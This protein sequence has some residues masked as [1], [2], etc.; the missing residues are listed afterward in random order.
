MAGGLTRMNFTTQETSAKAKLFGFT[1]AQ[2]SKISIVKIIGLV[3][4]VVCVVGTSVSCSGFQKKDDLASK[5]LSL[6][7]TALAQGNQTLA[8]ALLDETITKF[9][10]TPSAYRAR[11]VKADMLTDSGSYDDALSILNETLNV[12]KPDVIKPLAKAG[13]IYVYDSKKDYSSA[14]VASKEFIDKYPDHF[15]AKDICLNLAQ[16]HLMLG[17][18]DKAIRAFNKVLINFPKTREAKKAQN[19][20]NEIK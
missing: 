4:L 19:R 11:L 2:K 16:Y 5:K 14:I 6:A 8:I 7:Y 17:S 13:I 9:S 20:I 12:G 18:K 1:I 15:L 3:F 10:K